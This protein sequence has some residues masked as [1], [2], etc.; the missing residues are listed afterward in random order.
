MPCQRGV[1]SFDV[2]WHSQCRNWVYSSESS[3]NVLIERQPL[4]KEQ[5]VLPSHCLSRS[6]SLGD[7][8]PLQPSHPS[9]NPLPSCPLSPLGSMTGISYSYRGLPGA[10]Q[11]HVE[12]CPFLSISLSRSDNW[13]Q[14]LSGCHSVKLRWAETQGWKDKQGQHGFQLLLEPGPLP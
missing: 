7:N 10:W 12:G 9:P 2:T 13:Q 3:I 1:P 4:F 6:P 14:E 5:C 11:S 8:P